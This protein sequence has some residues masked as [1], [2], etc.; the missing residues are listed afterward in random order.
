MK[1]LRN[2][3]EMVVRSLIGFLE[4]DGF[5][6]WKAFNGEESLESS[7][8][9]KLADVVCACDEG[10]LYIRKGDSRFT[11]FI[12]LGNSPSEIVADYSYPRDQD[13]TRFEASWDK[14]QEYWE[15]R[16]DACPKKV[17]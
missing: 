8:K 4:K 14:F 5:E 2:D 13:C 10:W 11:L 1:T 15:N 6:A 9:R 12:V 17:S 16:G 7:S 3:W